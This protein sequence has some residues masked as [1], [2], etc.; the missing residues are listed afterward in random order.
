MVPRTGRAPRHAVRRAAARL[1]FAL[2]LLAAGSA[3]AGSL[4]DADS[5]YRFCDRHEPLGA[6]EQGRLLQFAAAIRGEL[7]ASG[8]SVA[9]VARSGQRS[10]ERF[11]QRYSH[12][13]I[14]LRG[15]ADTAWS[16]RQLYYACDEGVPRL[17]D[18]GLAGFVFGTDNPQLG[19]LSLVL[20]PEAAS[21]SL[22]QRA[23]DPATAMQVLGATYSANAYAFAQVYQNCNQWVA[24]LLALAWGGLDDAAG[25]AGARR[26]PD[27][28][29][30][31][32]RRAEAQ[33]W[34]QVHGYEPTLFEAGAPWL[35]VLRWFIP[36]VH[37]DDHPPEAQRTRSYRVSMPQ[38]IEAFVHA[39]VPGAERLELCHDEHR[40]VV[41]R[42]WDRMADGCKPAAGDRVIE[43]D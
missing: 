1:A 25:T 34:L 12:S 8:H 6:R 31:A 11:G 39:Q 33:D 43:M 14:S 41:H 4:A 28:G 40:V 32:S 13:G 38:S 26:G 15:N 20:L 9:I 23:L 29:A 30:P 16:V 36:W 27:E 42:G 17:F 21:R 37:D 2:G 7:E 22:E 35:R 19:Y 24:E 3:G 5:S 18:Q 10:L